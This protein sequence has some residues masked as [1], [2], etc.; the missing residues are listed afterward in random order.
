M[1]CIAN[2]YKPK[3]KFRQIQMLFTSLKEYRNLV[4]HVK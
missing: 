4:V 3:G 2:K 1:D